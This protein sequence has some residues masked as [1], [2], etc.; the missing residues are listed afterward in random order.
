VLPDFVAKTGTMVCGNEHLGGAKRRL[1]RSPMHADTE[2][3]LDE[4]AAQP[5]AVTCDETRA[6]CNADATMGCEGC[7]HCDRSMI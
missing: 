6:L 1:L 3:V 4:H 2:A 5:R 7:M